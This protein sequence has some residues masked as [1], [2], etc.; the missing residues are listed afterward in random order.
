MDWYEWV[1]E[2]MGKGTGVIICLG[3][4]SWCAHIIINS[5]LLAHLNRRV[6]ALE[7][8]FWDHGVSTLEDLFWRHKHRS[9]PP[10]GDVEDRHYSVARNFEEHQ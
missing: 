6:S 9:S 3:I 7:K 8:R 5:I 1:C 2:V 4:L 10:A